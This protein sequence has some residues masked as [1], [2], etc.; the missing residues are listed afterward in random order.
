MDLRIENFEQYDF[1]NYEFVIDDQLFC[2]T[3]LMLIRGETI[4]FSSMKKKQTVEAEKKLEEEIF[5]FEK[6]SLVSKEKQKIF[7][8]LDLK[9]N[10]LEELRKEKIQGNILRSSLKWAEFGEKPSKFFSKFR[11]TKGNK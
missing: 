6:E 4:S 7:E 1:V 8:D 9:R 11:K 3:L 2:D 10:T 5:D